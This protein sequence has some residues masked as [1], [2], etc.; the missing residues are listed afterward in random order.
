MICKRI[1][2]LPG[3]TI[4]Y[5]NLSS[6]GYA[7][8]TLDSDEV[9]LG[10]D[11][12]LGS[13]DSKN[14]G[15]LPLERLQ[16]KVVANLKLP[17]FKSILRRIIDLGLMF[18]S[19]TADEEQEE[20]NERVDV[21][22]EDDEDDLESDEEFSEECLDELADLLLVDPLT[23]FNIS[24]VSRQSPAEWLFLRKVLA[25]RESTRAIPRRKRAML[26][27]T[28]DQALCYLGYD[29]VEEG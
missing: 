29:D 20:K 23:C 15:P 4:V 22:E 27:I 28:V 3:D 6:R 14:Y 16:G 21:V 18:P 11:N 19:K 9:W 26:R 13:K 10:G 17:P 7:C 5:P 8:V 1:L 24:H 2:G 25:D 12:F